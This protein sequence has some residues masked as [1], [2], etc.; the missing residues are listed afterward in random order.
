MSKKKTL[1]VDDDPFIVELLTTRL[2]AAGFDVCTARDGEEAFAKAYSEKPHLIIMDVMMPRVSGYEALQ[3][4]RQ[5]PGMQKIPAIIFSGKAGM[6]DFF[7]G[8]PDV[9]FMLKPFD[10][11]LL[12]ARAEA[13]VGISRPHA[14]QSKQ[15]IL[16][17][18]EDRV[19]NKIRDFLVEHNFQI[20]VALNESEA[21]VLSKKNRPDMIFCQLWEDEHILA[22]WKIAQ[23][24]LSHLAISDIPLYVYCKEALS[25]EAMKHFKTERIL[26]Y[27]ET[28]DLLR[29]IETL[30]K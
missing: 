15:A 5:D 25:L 9:E 10:A 30:V 17:G 3:K 13:L 19:V 20:L 27:K 1:A 6:K 28:S 7:E 22:P 21:I 2:T 18:V 12:I 8:M 24:L 23:E 16:L 29:K 26:A 11:K 4:I 14:V